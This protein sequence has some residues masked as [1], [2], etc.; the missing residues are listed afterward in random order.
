MNMTGRDAINKRHRN[1][2]QQCLETHTTVSVL[3][4]FI[5]NLALVSTG[6]NSSPL[7]VCVCVWVGDAIRHGIRRE[8]EERRRAVHVAVGVGKTEL[9]SS[10]TR[11]L[12][13]SLFSSLLFVAL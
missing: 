7:C 5:Y 8:R 2:I 4:I 9:G 1:G 12:P 6:V 11:R 3:C 10:N 13:V